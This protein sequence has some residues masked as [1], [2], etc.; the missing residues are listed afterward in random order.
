VGYSG[1][2][3]HRSFGT[4]IVP[5]TFASLKS[6][7]FRWCFGGIQIL[8][9]HLRDLLPWNRDPRNQLSFGQRMD[10]FFSSLQWFNDLLYLGF[11]VVLQTTAALLVTQGRVGIR[12]LLGAVVLLP[13]HHRH[14]ERCVT[15]LYVEGDSRSALIFSTSVWSPAGRPREIFQL[16]TLARNERSRNS[17]LFVRVVPPSAAATA[18]RWCTVPSAPF[19]SQPKTLPGSSSVT[20]LCSRCVPN[21]FLTV[22]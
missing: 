6:Q 1:L 17:A 3:I 14:P 20:V 11:S 12:P 16:V 8:K 22:E 13:A 9:R 19:E 10:Y 7:R 4:G 21:C 15:K 2:Y 18:N 5:L